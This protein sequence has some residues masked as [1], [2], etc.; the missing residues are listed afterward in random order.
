M[1]NGEGRGGEEKR[2]MPTSAAAGARG[3]WDTSTET[4]CVSGGGT[5]SISGSTIDT[6]VS[7]E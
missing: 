6:D 1:G 7:S 3:S 5:R 2:T 4:A